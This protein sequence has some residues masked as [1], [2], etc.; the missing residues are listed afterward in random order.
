MNIKRSTAVGLAA[1]GVFIFA[2][3]ASCDKFTQPYQD[4]P[5]SGINN[6]PAETGTMPDGFNNWAAKCDG[7]NM[8]YTTFHGDYKYAAIAVAP[9]DSRCTGK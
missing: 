9:N 4:A 2:G 5:R 3:A 7:P 1:A 6:D 8:V